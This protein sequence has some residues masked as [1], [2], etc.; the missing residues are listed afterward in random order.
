MSRLLKSLPQPRCT[1]A[2]RRK[3]WAQLFGGLL[4]DAREERGRSVEEAAEAAGM[5]V[6]EWEAVED[7]RVPE[8][9]EKARRI[10]DGLGTDD[11]G[12][13]T[14]VLFCQEAWRK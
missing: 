7:G 13:A 10:S 2:F 12:M 1:A 8:N 4:R 14:L 11:L 3:A 9:W 6:A 5:K